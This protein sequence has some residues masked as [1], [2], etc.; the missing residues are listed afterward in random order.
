MDWTLTYNN[1]TDIQLTRRELRAV[2][3]MLLVAVLLPT[4]L[5]AHPTATRL[6]TDSINLVRTPQGGLRLTMTVRPKA[7]DDKTDRRQT[8][9]CVPHANVSSSASF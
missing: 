3:L 2:L 1:Q 7:T 4:T 6:L 9:I 8:L 5:L